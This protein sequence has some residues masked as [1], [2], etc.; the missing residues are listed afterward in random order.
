MTGTRSRRSRPPSSSASIPPPGLSAG[1]A[2]Q[3]LQKY[4]PNVLAEAE[5]EPAWKQFLKH[6]KD[7][8]QLVL[9]VAA[10]VSL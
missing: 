2:Q 4:G 8:M 1:E 6:Y 10:V 5:A 3:R 9:V 7:Y